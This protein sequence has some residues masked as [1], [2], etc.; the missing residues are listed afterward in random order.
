MKKIVSIMAIG[1]FSLIVF[2]CTPQAIDADTINPQ[3]CCG[4]DSH[5]PPPPSPGLNG[6]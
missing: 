6:G 5:F 4:D 2:S 1:L 3:S